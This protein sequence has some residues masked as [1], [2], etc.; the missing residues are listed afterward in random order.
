[1]KNEDK[2]VLK[3]LGCTL[4]YGFF[5]FLLINLLG[6]FFQGGEFFLNA[7]LYLGVIFT[8]FL[9]TFRIIDEIRKK[10]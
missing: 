6:M 9:C 3:A 10:K 8:I 5:M 7:L 1:M 2:I 4:G